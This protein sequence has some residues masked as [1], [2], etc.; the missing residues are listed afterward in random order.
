MTLPSSSQLS[1]V[2]EDARPGFASG[3]ESLEG[4]FQI[5]MNNVTREGGWDYSKKRYVPADGKL[6][7]RFR[8]EDG[9]V[10]FN[11]TNSPE[12]VGKTALVCEPTEPMV[13]SNH[14]LR[15][16]ADPRRL[17]QPYL[18][19]WLQLQF[20]RGIFASMCQ[21]WVN[22][23]AVKRDRLLAMTIP[24]PSL[25]D[26]RRIARVLDAADALRTARRDALSRL[27]LLPEA[28]FLSMFGDPVTNVQ[29]WPRATI[30]EIG[31][32]ITGNTPSRAIQ[33]NYGDYIGWVKS[34]NLGGQQTYVTLPTEFLSRTGAKMARVVGRNAILVTCIAG[35]PT[36]IGNL[37][38]T[39]HEVAFNQQINA[40]VPRRVDVKFLYTQLKLCKRLVQLASTGGMKGMVSKSRLMGIT[41]I[42]PPLELQRDFAARFDQVEKAKEQAGQSRS[43]LDALFASL[44]DRAFK[45]EL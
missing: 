44:Q 7:D 43:H 38:I 27:A 25:T 22:Q 9:D 30:G 42:N 14:F 21:R 32:V 3:V 19:R 35:S 4:V 33:S 20:E 6:V 8:L 40:V 41:L 28:Y 37:A 11:A 29:R 15:L 10:L 16:R 2:I 31:D 24:L 45:G 13:F 12:L 1:E 5:R 36:S 26:Q 17:L 34:D 18:A 39:D 23:A